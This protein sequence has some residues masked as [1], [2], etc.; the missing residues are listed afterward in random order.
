MDL[1]D[2]QRIKAQVRSSEYHRRI[3][4]VIDQKV[5]PRTFMSGDLVL[6]SIEATGKHVG[7]LS[8]KWEGPF[9]VIK[10]CLNGAYKLESM[11][12][13]LIPRTWNAIHLKRFYT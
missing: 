10:S 7:K 2:E 3:K 9:R 8:P 1:V 12:G 13:E 5:S 11:S 4:R 6:R